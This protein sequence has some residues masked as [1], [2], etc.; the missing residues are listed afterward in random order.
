MCRLPSLRPLHLPWDQRRAQTGW[1]L[2]YPPV[3]LGRASCTQQSLAQLPRTR[4]SA[5]CSAWSVQQWGSGT[6]CAHCVLQST[7]VT[8][9]Y[10]SV[11]LLL[12]VRVLSSYHPLQAV[13]SRICAS[14]SQRVLY[15][16][17]YAAVA[18]CSMCMAVQRGSDSVCCLGFEGR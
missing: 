15:L 11:T 13:L 7:R 8:T 12:S 10:R 18:S 4:M 6:A 3:I 9:L 14:F 1:N 2:S 17:P 5:I 16:P